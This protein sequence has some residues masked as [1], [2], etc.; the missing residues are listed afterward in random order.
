M[1]GDSPEIL[2]E[3][4]SS[5]HNGRNSHKDEKYRSRKSSSKSEP[6]KD[7]PFE[8]PFALQEV[9]DALPQASSQPPLVEFDK[10]N[11]PLFEQLAQG[12]LDCQEMQN[13]FYEDIRP[14]DRLLA[15]VRTANA[16][17]LDVEL[18]CTMNRIRRILSEAGLGRFKIMHDRTEY[19][20]HTNDLIEV[21]VDQT[22]VDQP[23]AP[24]KIK[25]SVPPERA[26]LKTAELPSFYRKATAPQKEGEEKSEKPQRFDEY[27]EVRAMIANPSANYALGFPRR[28]DSTAL[29]VF[30]GKRLRPENE[31]VESLKERQ[32]SELAVGQITKA[33]AFIKEGLNFEAIQACNNALRHQPDNTDALL[34]RAIAAHNMDN[35]V[36]AIIDLEKVLE[37][38]PNHERAKKI[39][40]K[41]LL[42]KGEEA[43]E[44]LD[45]SLAKESY[46]KALQ[47]DPNLEEA[48]HAL[49]RLAQK[50]T[51]KRKNHDVIDLTEE[52]PQIKRVDPKS[53]EEL[54]KNRKKL[55]EIEKFKEKL[56]KMKK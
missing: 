4:F 51:R 46:E 28:L 38:K 48:T 5:R 8:V 21:I 24:Q 26:P 49:E 52:K 45:N 1:A 2:Y 22:F 35:I 19:A 3:S 32:L 53:A 12:H 39:L 41:V 27:P 33:G 30:E 16:I 54:E 40:A 43:E 47:H 14:G 55:A 42:E 29:K 18:L 15:R 17:M 44:K 37:T 7:R 31:S 36:S 11:I 9:F 6:D 20:Y 56:K 10:N 13:R 50:P 25:L 23:D 34:G